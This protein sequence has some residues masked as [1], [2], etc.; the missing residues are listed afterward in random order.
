[1]QTCVTPE[2]K[3]TVG[4]H[5][6]GFEVHNLRETETTAVLGRCSDGQPVENRINF[7]SSMVRAEKTDRIYEV[8]NPFPF[9][10]T[11]F[12]N[13]AWADRHAGRPDTV[14]VP[15]QPDCSLT[16]GVRTWLEKSPE[17]SGLKDENPLFFSGSPAPAPAAGPG[18]GLNRSP[19]TGRP[20]VPGLHPGLCPGD[21][22]AA[23]RGLFYPQG[24][25]QIPS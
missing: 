7:P 8:A 6:P 24:R 9:R 19:G 10:G 4:I 16:A 21:R 13:S 25:R 1:M 23:H 17:Q 2:G 12:I 11:T 14:T 22:P 5:D 15:R 20:G 3:F 18:P